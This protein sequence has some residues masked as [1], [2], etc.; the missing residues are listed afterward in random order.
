VAVLR[1]DDRG[2][3]GST[4]R[5][6]LESATT[7]LLAE[8]TR[9][10]IAWLRRRAEVDPARVIVIGHSEGATIA[11]MVAASDPKLFA[12]VMMAGPGRRGGDTSIEQQEDILRADT[13]LTDS[14]RASL[15]AQQQE[16]VRTVLAGGEIPGQKFNPWVREFFTYDPLPAVRK[17]KQP[18]LILQGERDRQVSQAHATLLADAAR[19]AGNTRVTMQVF[20]TLNHLFLPSKT[21][22]FAEYGHLEASAVPSNVLDAIANWIGALRR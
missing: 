20:P 2:T 7:T 11:A 13:T 18:L 8:D 1:V 22:S 16:A 6:T 10:Q 21:G 4:G 14:V 12:V 5:E 3:G 15:R 9:A 17:V 19:S